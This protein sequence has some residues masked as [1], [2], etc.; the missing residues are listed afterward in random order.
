MTGEKGTTDGARKKRGHM[1]RAA[2]YVTET[3]RSHKSALQWPDLKFIQTT[4]IK[5][6]ARKKNAGLNQQKGK[7]K[8][9]SKKGM[10]CMQHQGPDFKMATHQRE[11]KGRSTKDK[12]TEIDQ[13]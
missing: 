5:C 4:K 13:T 2:R 10:A 3:E 9:N 7:V 1:R 6:E 8:E 12:T 11:I